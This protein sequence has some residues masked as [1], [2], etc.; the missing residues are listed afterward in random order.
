MILLFNCYY[1]YCYYYHYL[2]IYFL[3]PLDTPDGCYASYGPS[4]IFGELAV[5]WPQWH[6]WTFS[7]SLLSLKVTGPYKAEAWLG[8]PFHSP[9]WPP[10]GDSE[11]VKNGGHVIGPRHLALWYMEITHI[12]HTQPRMVP[13]FLWA[14]SQK[15][16]TIGSLLTLGKP[17]RL[18]FWKGQVEFGWF[19]Q[20]CY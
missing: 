16:R 5:A 4:L 12:L 11:D 14:L 1:Y 17:Y 20:V 3:D 8:I 6:I 9:H 18:G 7:R 2:F 13:Q 15:G 10:V 19:V